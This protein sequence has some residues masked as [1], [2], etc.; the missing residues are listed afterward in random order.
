MVSLILLAGFL[1]AE[2]QHSYADLYCFIGLKAW[3]GPS[4]EDKDPSVHP[5]SILHG[6]FIENLSLCLRIGVKAGSKT[7]RVLNLMKP[8]VW[9]S[10]EQ[11]MA[12]NKQ[13]K[14]NKQ[15]DIIWSEVS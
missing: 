14:I 7:D 9:W 11:E 3:Q 5:L 6:I 12:I 1:G 2:T 15:D 8:R 10:G 4:Q 13:T